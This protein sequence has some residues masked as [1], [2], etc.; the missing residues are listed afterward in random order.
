MTPHTYLLE[1]LSE[2]PRQELQREAGR[3]RLLAQL[4]HQRRSLGKY[5]ARKLGVLLLWPG[6]RLRQ[7]E[8]KSPVTIENHP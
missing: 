1:K 5:M 2:A 7:F 4:P 6:A 8:Q 3:E